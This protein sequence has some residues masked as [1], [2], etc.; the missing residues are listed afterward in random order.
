MSLP[1]FIACVSDEHFLR[2]VNMTEGWEICR[3]PKD[4]RVPGDPDSSSIIAAF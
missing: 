2:T 1:H 4:V 3:I